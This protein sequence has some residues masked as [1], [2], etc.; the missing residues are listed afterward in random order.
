MVIYGDILFVLNMTVDYL[1]IGMT[2]TI[3]KID[4]KLFRQ[5]LASVLGGV[6][7]F[8]IFIESGIIVIDLLYRLVIALLSV[9]IVVGAKHPQRMFKALA[10]YFTLSLLL[11]GITGFISNTFKV[12]QLAVNNTF[13]YVGIS[14]LM[15]I[16]LSVIFYFTVTVVNRVRKNKK[17]FDCCRV[18]ITVLGREENFSALIDSGN[19]ITDVISNSEIFIACENVPEKLLGMKI[20]NIFENDELTARCRL[21]P[22][23]T[24]N[25][26]AVL[27]AIRCDKGVISYNGKTFELNKP[28]IAVSKYI[29]SEEYDLIVPQGVLEGW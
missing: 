2:V 15:L 22:T 13:F 16:G 27:P 9:M 20:E 23:S 1:L 7:A 6:S 5:I 10:V 26:R 28:I 14:P 19:T 3:L 21:I 4:A 24:V 17:V 25:G 29:K 12:T 11:S 18:S 8:Y